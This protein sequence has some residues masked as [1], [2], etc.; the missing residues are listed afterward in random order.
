M[1]FGYGSNNESCSL[2]KKKHLKFEDFSKFPTGDRFMAPTR[3]FSKPAPVI[4]FEDPFEQGGQVLKVVQ[5]K[6]VLEAVVQDRSSYGA[7][8]S[9]FQ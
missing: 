2:R 1:E 6:L 4:G 8:T 3:N 5:G 7:K 9:F